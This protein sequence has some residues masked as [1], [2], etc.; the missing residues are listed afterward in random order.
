MTGGAYRAFIYGGSL[1]L[2]PP[3]QVMC[4]QTVNAA[5]ILFAGVL[6][7]ID[8]FSTERFKKM[9]SGDTSLVKGKTYFFHGWW[10][11]AVMFALMFGFW[12]PFIWLAYVAHMFIDGFGK[13]LV[14]EPVPIFISK[15]V[16]EN[17]KYEM[18]TG[19][20]SFVHW[21]LSLYGRLTTWNDLRKLC[22]RRRQIM[23]KAVKELKKS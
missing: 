21:L 8:H 17:W 12:S 19:K 4:V 14:N 3:R 23:K 9:R 6:I 1:Y 5:V 2:D 16:P 18:K 20:G 13:D 15:F 10:G 22:K 11:P 7:D